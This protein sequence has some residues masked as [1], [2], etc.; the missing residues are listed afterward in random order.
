MGPFCVQGVRAHPLLAAHT[1]RMLRAGGLTR[2]SKA[3]P[4]LLAGM[5]CSARAIV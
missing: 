1:E 3:S 4:Q 2:A 5:A